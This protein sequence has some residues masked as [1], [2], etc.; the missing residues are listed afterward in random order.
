MA[1]LTCYYIETASTADSGDELDLTG[2]F[3]DIKLV[4][5]WENEHGK[6]LVTNVDG[7]LA[8]DTGGARTDHTYHLLV[9]GIPKK[10][11]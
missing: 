1:G 5:A 4:H 2:Y 8:I 11:V 6:I 3:Y 7:T 9:W 10:G